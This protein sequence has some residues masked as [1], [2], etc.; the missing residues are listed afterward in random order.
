VIVFLFLCLFIYRA[1]LDDLEGCGE[2]CTH[3]PVHAS[4]VRLRLRYDTNILVMLMIAGPIMRYFRILFF[5]IF[6][7]SIAECPMP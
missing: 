3:G 4:A 6:G 2:S 7:C 1:T 5:A